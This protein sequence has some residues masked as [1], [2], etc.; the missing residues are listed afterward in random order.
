MASTGGGGVAG[1]VCSR[2]AKKEKMLVNTCRSWMKSR[3]GEKDYTD[4]MLHKNSKWL[5]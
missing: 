4:M 5:M 3:C 1:V 2:E